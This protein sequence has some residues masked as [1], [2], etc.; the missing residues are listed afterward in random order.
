MS[1]ISRREG[2]VF[3]RSARTI[4]DGLLAVSQEI[5]QDGVTARTIV[6]GAFWLCPTIVHDEGF[7]EVGTGGA[8]ERLPRAA[9]FLI[10]PRSA[11]RLRLTDVRARCAGLA[12]CVPL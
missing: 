12:G 5:A 2:L 3:E 4:S 6:T 9:I 8:W 11:I 7:T 1:V 10:P